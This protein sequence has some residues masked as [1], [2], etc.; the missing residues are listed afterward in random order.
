MTPAAGVP[1]RPA[2][3][4]WF[5]AL[6]AAIVYLPSFGGVFQFDDY[7]VIADYPV[8]HSWAGWWS[9]LGQGVR[10]LLKASYT[11]NWTLGAGEFGFHLVNIALHALNTALLVL[12]GRAICAR[13]VG[14][15]RAAGCD[16]AVF[17]AA[18][19]FA[20][21]PAQ[22]EA[23]TY[24][25]GRSV[26]LMTGFYLGALLVYLRGGH[27][28]ISG[29]LFA[30]AAATRET[31]ITLPAVLLLVEL[32]SRERA[33]WRTL[34]R[35]QTVHWALLC[36]GL[37]VLLF[38]AR[39][40]SLVSF[41]YT[42]RS[43]IDNLITQVGGIAHLCAV[44]IGLL[45]SNIDPALPALHE[46]SGAL[47]AQAVLLAALVML[48]LAQLRTRPWIAFGLLWFFIQLA[49]TNS[50]VPRL[51]VVNDRQLYLAC[52]GLFLALCIQ[53]A[54]LRP[55]RSHSLAM[56]GALCVVL[57]G[58]SVARQLDYR[59][60]IALWGA[61]VRAAPWNA[62]AHANLGY[63][64]QLA[65]RKAE[66]RREFE[67]ALLFGPRERKARYNLLLLD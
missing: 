58:A 55:A 44:L 23:V 50:I 52:W 60:E 64:Y 8:V 36:A 48:G 38:N 5:A 62:R 28:A 13:C 1:D 6:A 26:S 46:W 39:Y 4:A 34:L 51:D 67:A 41:G 21:H 42:Q 61:S 10:P 3:H 47:A 18:L 17:I 54:Q 9:G 24:I 59:S 63:A 22:T 14:A 43:L 56:A 7:R 49:P 40:L 11:L 15:P 16:G 32:C 53:I 20:L 57:A 33:G 65:G 19:L 29:A 27:W 45:G 31:A 66:A 12:I 2:R 30:L 25:S 35:R 37:L